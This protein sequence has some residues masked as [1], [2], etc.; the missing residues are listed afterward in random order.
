MKKIGIVFAMEQEFLPVQSVLGEFVKK[1][2]GVSDEL[3]PALSEL[4]TPSP[5]KPSGFPV[6]V[7][8]NGSKIICAVVSG[9]GQIRAAAAT[10]LLISKYGAECIL[11][12]GLCGGLTEGIRTFDTVLV[13]SVVQADFDISAGCNYVKG[14]HGGFGSPYI[15]TD[16]RLLEKA[17]RLAEY[18]VALCA[19]SDRFVDTRED[20]IALNKEF[21]A[22]ICEM[23]AAG[24]ILVASLNGIPALF[25]KTVSD[26]IG[27]GSAEFFAVAD[28]A[29]HE[30]RDFLRK[31]IREI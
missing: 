21:G 7:Y 6:W 30:Y 17:I 1:D 20:R 16:R 5:A 15:E 23:E 24:V 22:H 27:G 25:V 11:N 2:G 4:F 9:V 19:S 28:K 3:P 13:D 14:Q 12:F 26:S 18:P 31:L 29:V 10:Q 8:K